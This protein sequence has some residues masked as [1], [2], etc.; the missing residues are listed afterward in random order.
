MVWPRRVS[1]YRTIVRNYGGIRQVA[2]RDHRDLALIA[3]LDPARWAATSAPLS[4][5]RSDPAFLKSLDPLGSGRVRVDQVLDAAQWT[6][7]RLGNARRLVERSDVLVLADLRDDEEGRR[8]ANVAAQVQ[9]QLELPDPQ[10]LRLADVRAYQENYRRTLENGDGIVP[11]ACVEDAQTAAL[12]Q[13]IITCVGSR[14]DAS[15]EPGV[16]TA[17]IDLFVLEGTRYLQWATGKEAAIAAVRAGFRPSA[18]AAADPE[19]ALDAVQAVAVAFEDWLVRSATLWA[20]GAQGRPSLVEQ[21][22]DHLTTLPATALNEALLQ[23]PLAPLDPSCSLQLQ[24]ALNPN[25]TDRVGELRQRAVCPI[26]G[27]DVQCL[28]RQGWDQIQAVLRPIA[29]WRAERPVGAFDALE[30]GALQ[31]WLAPERVQA[32]RA[33]V[34]QDLAAAPLI[35]DADSLERLILCHRWILELVNN[36][37]NF[38]SIYDPGRTALLDI[39]SLVIDGRRL[40]FCIPVRD[41]HAHK[42]VAQES[43]C[44][45]V[46]A[47][48][49][50]R[51]GAAAAFTIAAPVTSGERG[52]IRIGKRGIFL[53]T[54]NK[55]YDAVVTDIL[56]HPISVKEAAL[57]PFRRAA[58]F[59][60]QKFEEWV[61]KQAAA[62]DAG[63]TAHAEQ[64]L[65]V[66][67]AAVEKDVIPV[68]A[69]PTA[70]TPKPP[71][72]AK[73]AEPAKAAMAAKASPP[74]EG[75]NAN[76][77]ILGGGMAL[78]G[79]GAVLA[80]AFSALTTLSGWLSILAIIGTIAGFSALLGW[81]KL[82]RRDMSLLLEANGWAVNLQMPIR[83]RV[84]L[85]FTFVPKLPSG[86][87][88]ERRDQLAGLTAEDDQRRNKLTVLMVVLIVLCSAAAAWARYLIAP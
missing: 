28:D 49:Y 13:A 27:D 51:E 88:I 87:R 34:A 21:D 65:K 50:E 5:L 41:I 61:G 85:L 10:R 7:Q 76:S 6:L 64:G 86:H 2:V 71:E 39:G 68:V 40:N 69:P 26:L 32:L 70:A 47:E 11:V 22:K 4:D 16:G 67:T 57:A 37:V 80:S 9:R 15:G 84:G 54:D 14:P 55:Q 48:I 3:Q 44:F 45:L 56:E 74:K 53:D 23:A 46:Y 60:S 17:E 75:I 82:R 18:G 72:P 63:A 19:A 77:L 35:A 58:R 81:L 8:L 52:R 25:W 66:T 12:V 24:A 62:A 38:S 30:P 31:D 83:R 33:L 79:F 78:A 59:V 43:L 20:T 1:L 29:T 42:P 36:F 73:P